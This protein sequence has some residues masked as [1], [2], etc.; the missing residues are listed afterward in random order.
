MCHAAPCRAVLAQDRREIGV[1]VA[2]VEEHGFAD[3]GR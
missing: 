1:R 3:P 2:L